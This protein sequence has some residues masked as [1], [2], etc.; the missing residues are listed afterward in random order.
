[1]QAGSNSYPIPPSGPVAAAHDKRRPALRQ[2]S[3]FFILTALLALIVALPVFTVISFL[4]SPSTDT[5]QHLAD[6]VLSDYVS[7][8]LLLMLGVTIGAGSMG[9]TMAWLVSMYEFPG[10][11]L[12]TWSLLLPL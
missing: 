5:W 12:F 2:P 3:L 8:S 11:G 4:F 9:V 10:R 6:T 1:M 7:N